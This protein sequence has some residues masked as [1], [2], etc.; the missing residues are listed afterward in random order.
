[1]REFLGLFSFGFCKY[2]MLTQKISHFS[3][4]G[5]SQERKESQRGRHIQGD[6]SSDLQKTNSTSDFITF[7]AVCIAFTGT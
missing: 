1:M 2:K 4:E 3:H 6:S 5:N 7:V